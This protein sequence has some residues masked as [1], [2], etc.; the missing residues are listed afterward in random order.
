MLRPIYTYYLIEVQ[1]D[2]T[3]QCDYYYSFPSSVFANETTP[4]TDETLS[5]LFVDGTTYAVGPKAGDYISVDSDHT[6]NLNLPSVLKTFTYGNLGTMQNAKFSVADFEKLK[7][8][9]AVLGFTA[10]QGTTN[11]VAYMFR[12][13]YTALSQ[14]SSQTAQVETIKLVCE[15]N[16]KMS[17][18]LICDYNTNTVTSSWTQEDVKAAP[19]SYRF[20]LVPNDV[21]LSLTGTAGRTVESSAT[22]VS[23]NINSGVK[24]FLGYPSLL[25]R[26]YSALSAHATPAAVAPTFMIAEVGAGTDT[27]KKL[28]LFYCPSWKTENTSIFPVT[29]SSNLFANVNSVR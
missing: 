12:P 10:T 15:N 23:L 2:N 19:T 25:V 13:V 28:E 18:T 3:V 7:Y 29:T 4:D 21:F 16:P 1:S 6:V 24:D 8:Q 22:D 5:A 26:N 9:A 27:G 20:P 17:V 14:T 11:A